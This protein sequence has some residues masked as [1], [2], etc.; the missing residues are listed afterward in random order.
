MKDKFKNGKK[1][2]LVATK[3]PL[4]KDPDPDSSILKQK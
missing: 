3:L 1:V 4:G 2:W